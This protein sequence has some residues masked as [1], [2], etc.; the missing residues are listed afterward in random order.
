[1]AMY[2]TPGSYA[3]RD[4]S[5][6][7]LDI[8]DAS[9]LSN[10][11][12]IEVTVVTKDP[13]GKS[14][15]HFGERRVHVDEITRLDIPPSELAKVYLVKAAGKPIMFQSMIWVKR[16]FRTYTTLAGDDIR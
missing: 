2:G 15:E 10:L 12:E 11:L 4:T 3:L 14:D 16:G 13:A 5:I 9:L 6:A 8:A 1:M 7:T